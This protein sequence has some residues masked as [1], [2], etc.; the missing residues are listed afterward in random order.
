MRRAG[1]RIFNLVV[2][3]FL[4]LAGC[5]TEP[6]NELRDP[7]RKAFT[8]I[9]S[10]R[11]YVLASTLE[12]PRTMVVALIDIDFSESALRFSYAP[13]FFTSNPQ[14]IVQFEAL[15]QPNVYKTPGA[16]ADALK[17]RIE[18]GPIGILLMLDGEPLGIAGAPD[19]D[20][21]KAGVIR[22]F[23]KRLAAKAIVF[24]FIVPDRMILPTDF[25]QKNRMKTEMKP[26]LP[27]YLIHYTPKMPNLQATPEALSEGWE[28]AEIG[29]VAAFHEASRAQP[30]NVTFRALWDS[31]ALYIRF[32]VTDVSVRSIRTKQLG[33]VWCD[34][35]VEF[36]VTP[37]ELP[38]HFNFEINPGGMIHYSYIRNPQRL[39]SGEYVDWTLGDEASIPSML[40]H[41]SMPKTVSPEQFGEIRWT[42][43]YRVPFSLLKRYEPAFVEPTEGDVWRGNFFICGDELKEPRWGAWADIGKELAFHQPSKFGYLRF[44]R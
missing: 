26:S 10:D 40:I 41:H 38:K 9:D 44:A 22:D 4:L 36:F 15:D 5:A 24:T 28:L 33:D 25:N 1:F 39:S 30:K 29:Q 12:S 37:T 2:G 13:G 42:V 27:T 18:S 32:D 6:V 14:G 21:G 8:P 35:C 7:E 20:E 16:L 43:A 17:E 23:A 34:S 31:E 11:P 19:L 3:A